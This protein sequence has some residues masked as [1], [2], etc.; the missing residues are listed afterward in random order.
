MEW[1]G[2]ALA[3]A[4]SGAFGFGSVW[5]GHRVRNRMGLPTPLEEQIQN[6]EANL[7]QLLTEAEQRCQT[8]LALEKQRTERLEHELDDERL[9][10]RRLEQRIL[11]LEGNA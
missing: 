9:Y 5:L 10:T 1:L 7:R 4:I 3:A 6:Q 2:A 8:D 11:S